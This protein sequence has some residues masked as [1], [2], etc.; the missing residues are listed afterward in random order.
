MSGRDVV[1]IFG[2]GPIGAAT[3]V[4]AKAMG[5]RVIAVDVLQSRVAFARG[6]G[7]DYVIDGSKT[8]A[9][10]EILSVSGGFGADAAIDTSGSAQ[11]Q[12]GAL[13]C[14][15]YLGQVAFVGLNRKDLLIQP[16]RH[17]N[18]RQLTIHGSV[19]YGI[20]EFEEIGLFVVNQ[21]API[22]KIVSD[23]CRVADAGKAFAMFDTA[24]SA[25]KIVF[26]W[27]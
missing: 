7:A 10:K 13:E 16:L 1:A 20:D 11:G 6:L 3:I 24:Q 12:L 15:R 25:G 21:K 4:M 2:A 19:I 27:E 17:V 14:T 22:E 5:A 9:V 8:D 18:E 26:E 23:V